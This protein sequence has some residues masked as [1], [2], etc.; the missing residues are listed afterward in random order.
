MSKR[1]PFLRSIAALLRT[2]FPGAERGRKHGSRY[3]SIIE[4]TPF[5]VEAD[6]DARWP[7]VHDVIA[8][9][10][11]EYIGDE[12]PRLV[13]FKQHRREPLAVMRIT[14]FVTFLEK[15]IWRPDGE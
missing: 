8:R 12:R 2:T 7:E 6:H 14:D 10:E 11:Q 4:G 15:H 5:F 13:I 9:S 1:I 3:E